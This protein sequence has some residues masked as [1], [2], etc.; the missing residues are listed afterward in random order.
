M[1]LELIDGQV[2]IAV[3]DSG[4]GIPEKNRPFVFD[5]F[6][7]AKIPGTSGEVPFGLGLSISLQIARA[8]Q[9]NIWFDTEEGKGTTFHFEFP[10]KITV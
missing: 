2:H 10:T 8:H 1:S 4:V 6:T 7:Q 9:G 5:M 3:K